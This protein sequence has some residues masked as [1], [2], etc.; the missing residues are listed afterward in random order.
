MRGQGLSEWT[1]P[2]SSRVVVQRSDRPCPHDRM[3]ATEHIADRYDRSGYRQRKH[4]RK[5]PGPDL[6]PG[7]QGVSFA[8]TKVPVMRS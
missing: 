6:R 7:G 3:A 5:R 1:A 2:L 8:I 4:I